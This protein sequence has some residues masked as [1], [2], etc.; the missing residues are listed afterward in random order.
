MLQVGNVTY[1]HNIMTSLVLLTAVKCS[2]I[3]LTYHNECKET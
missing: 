3:K 2:I 1:K